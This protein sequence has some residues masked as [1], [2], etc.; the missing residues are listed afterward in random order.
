MLHRDIHCVTLCSTLCWKLWCTVFLCTV[1]WTL[2]CTVYVWT[3]ECL[4]ECDS[5]VHNH[6]VKTP[7]SFCLSVL[8]HW[9]GSFVVGQKD[10]DITVLNSIKIQ[11][12]TGKERINKHVQHIDTWHFIPLWTSLKPQIFPFTTPSTSTCKFPHLYSKPTSV[13]WDL[14]LL[15]RVLNVFL[16]KSAKKGTWHDA[17]AIL[18]DILGSIYLSNIQRASRNLC[19]G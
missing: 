15:G 19:V 7:N 3:T 2:W 1:Y 18:C 13:I 4:T 10:D 14:P 5:T 9:L 8:T 6:L 12:S 16:V 11:Y 17:T